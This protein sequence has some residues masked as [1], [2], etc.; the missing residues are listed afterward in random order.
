MIEHIPALINAQIFSLKIEGR[1]KGINYLA[2]VVKTYRNAI[3]AYVENP[4]DYRIKEEWRKELFQVYHRAYSTGFYFGDSEAQAPNYEN[5]HQ[6]KIHSF[7][8]KVLACIGENRFLVE[9]RNKI[10]RQDRV[11]ILS[12]KGPAMESG[13]LELSDPDQNSIENAQPNIRAF[14]GLAHHCQ[15]NDIIRKR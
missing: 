1:M 4:K 9:I 12:P 2:S 5:R 7:I 11:E 13:I 15:P 3:D 10:Y 6:G 14:I 8:G